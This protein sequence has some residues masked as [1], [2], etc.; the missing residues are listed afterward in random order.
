MYIENTDFNPIFF[1]TQWYGFRLIQLPRYKW[2]REIKITKNRGH[3]CPQ[4]CPSCIAR[5]IVSR[6]LKKFVKIWRDKRRY[7]V[8]DINYRQVH[9]RFKR[10]RIH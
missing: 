2:I 4:P 5:F 6:L 8:K 9:G 1:N 10:L 3:F 7:S